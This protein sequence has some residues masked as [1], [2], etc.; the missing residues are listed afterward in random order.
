MALL[1]VE[2]DAPEIEILDKILTESEKDKSGKVVLY[3]TGKLKGTAKPNPITGGLN[4]FQVEKIKEC[5]YNIR[6]VDGAICSTTEHFIWLIRRRLH[7][8]VIRH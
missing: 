4:E 5:V 1:T 3:K 7:F 2:S 6:N 8:V